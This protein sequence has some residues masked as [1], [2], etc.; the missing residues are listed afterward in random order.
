MRKRI[1]L[2][3]FLLILALLGCA[4]KVGVHPGAVSN[5]DSYAYDVL[6]VEQDVLTQAKAD[7]TAGKLP[8]QAKDPI[9]AAVNQ[10][11]V[12]QAA[13]QSYHAGGGDATTLQQALAS[14]VA[15][16]GE[17]QKLIAPSK[18]PV[19]ISANLSLRRAA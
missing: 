7:F 3:S 13:W 8:P 19:V 17:V 1:K 12:T 14:L 15:A 9:N 16:V 5:L 18:K 4:K 10:Y 11:N 2:L 6:L